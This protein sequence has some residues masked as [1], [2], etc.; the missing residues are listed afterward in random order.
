[1]KNKTVI[2]LLLILLLPILLFL[3]GVRVE[4]RIIPEHTEGKVT[5]SIKESGTYFIGENLKIHHEKI[6]DGTIKVIVRKNGEETTTNFYDEA[7][8]DTYKMEIM[9]NSIFAE[10]VK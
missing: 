3:S 8:F 10:P 5:I 2:I 1:M 4:H 6:P 9:T 7:D